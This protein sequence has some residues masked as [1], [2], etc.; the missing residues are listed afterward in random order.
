[1]KALRFGGMAG[2]GCAAWVVCLVLGLAGS[3][4]AQQVASIAV[5]F[6]VDGG[7]IKAGVDKKVTATVISDTGELKALPGD[8][9]WTVKDR[10]GYNTT[11]GT[12][13]ALTVKSAK[14]G[15]AREKSNVVNV[16]AEK[17]Y[18]YIKLTGCYRE[19]NIAQVCKDT[20]LWVGPGDPDRV[21]IE[22]SQDSINA[23]LRIARRIDRIAIGGQET[24]VENFYGIVRDRFG[25]WV[26]RAATTT[27]TGTALAGTSMLWIT[28]ALS[29]ATADVAP[30]NGNFTG[31]TATNISKASRGQGRVSRVT[32]RDG[33]TRL[34]AKYIMPGFSSI[35]QDTAEIVLNNVNYTDIRIVVKV[36]NN[37]PVPITSGKDQPVGTISTF[38]GVDT[39]IYAELYDPLNREWVGIPVTWT[40]VNNSVPGAAAP[41]G[42]A[43]Y[44]AITPIAP[45][46]A[47]G[48]TIT[49][50]T[51]NGLTAT[52]K[53]VAVN[54]D[55][56]GTCIFTKRGTPDF[57]KSVSSYLLPAALPSTAQPYARPDQ[58]VT[59]TAGAALP[60]VSKIFTDD[61]PSASSWL[62]ESFSASAWVWS[63]VNGAPGT[64]TTLSSTTGDSVAFRSTV[65]HQRHR[66]RVVFTKSGK[67]P[68]Q[69]DII[70]SVVPDIR[71]A[72]VTIENEWQMTTANA[73]KPL[74]VPE[75]AFASNDTTKSVYAVLRDQYGN[76]IAPSGVEI[77]VAYGVPPVVKT[78]GWTPKQ[79]TTG[80]V[81][82]E[83]GQISQGQGNVTRTFYTGTDLW[84]VV[85]DNTYN[86]KDSVKARLLNYYYEN[87]QIVQKCATSNIGVSGY[88]SV[89]STG[90]NITTDDTTTLFVIGKCGDGN[91]DG[92]SAGGWELAPGDWGAQRR[93]DERLDRAAERFE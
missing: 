49:A 44:W 8:F 42:T 40:N 60:L 31:P 12:N 46:T 25:N 91:C 50:S 77:P 9:T 89:P 80:I 59:V 65:A 19:G 3:V 53:I 32:E 75:L 76:Y 55:P 34:Y 69:Q 88:C 47:A 30:G 61:I 39:A 28:N 20:L 33:R 85:T 45:T 4:R 21:W 6:A 1:M 29:I 58:F 10:G 41:L 78:P 13:P 52:A 64:G 43:S 56:A 63:F 15:V 93:I 24:F 2:L 51:A 17:A 72:A 84:V 5:T 14:P 18:T 90:I 74:K 83:N 36:G 22:V 37:M 27:E 54:K 67:V 87:I 82:A 23:N 66:V 79:P 57:S 48:G 26:R 86:K 16:Y 68:V 71:T 92:G 7:D 70:I 81:Y 38:V 35:K 11:T 62:D 73:N